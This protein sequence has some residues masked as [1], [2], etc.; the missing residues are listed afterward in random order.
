MTVDNQ[1]AW[2]G[3]RWYTNAFLG[4]YDWF[5]LGLHCR[6]IWGCDSKTIVDFYSK[7]VS[8]NH[9]D[10]GTGTGYFLDKCHFPVKSPRLTLVDLNPHSLDISQK[11]LSRYHPTVYCRDVLRPPGIGASGF[12]SISITH[13]LHCLPGDMDSKGIVFQNLKPLL[14]PGG[15]L[16]GCTFI[17]QTSKYMPLTSVLTRLANKLGFMSNRNDDV[18]GLSRQIEKYFAEY[19][20]EIVGC[21]VFFQA[22]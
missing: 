5:A 10:V 21:E 15:V 11:R 19:S 8:G 14:N 7:H 6:F 2:D 17:Q 3:T 16:F 12:D 13:L 9:L 22:R 4:I 1:K 18:S 20:L